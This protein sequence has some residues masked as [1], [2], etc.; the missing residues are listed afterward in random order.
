MHYDCTYRQS[1]IAM[2]SYRCPLHCIT[3][4]HLLQRLLED[5]DKEIREAALSTLLASTNLRAERSLRATFASAGT[6]GGGRRTIFDCQG[7]RDLS[8]AVTARTEDGPASS[9]QAVNRVFDN[10]GVT[11]DFY[12]EV[13]D[14][15]SIDD[16]GM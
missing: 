11:R 1:E 15:S 12:K 7:G 5:P 4:P 10:F 13:F 8:A 9:D 2:G 3:P 6:P 16:R 14:R